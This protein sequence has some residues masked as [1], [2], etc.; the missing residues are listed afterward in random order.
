M[1]SPTARFSLNEQVWV[2]EHVGP[3]GGWLP[4][5]KTGMITCI[6][7]PY[8]SGESAPSGLPT[9]TVTFAGPNGQ[10]SVGDLPEDDLIHVST[11]GIPHPDDLT[12]KDAKTLKED[13]EADINHLVTVYQDR[14]GLEVKQISLDKVRYFH[15]GLAHLRVDAEVKL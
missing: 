3:N 6:T 15:G 4:S 5:R 1:T 8:D 12:V 11:P 13:L 14:T 9:Y 7:T 2:K 10:Y